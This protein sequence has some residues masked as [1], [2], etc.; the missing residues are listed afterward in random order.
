MTRLSSAAFLILSCAYMTNGQELARPSLIFDDLSAPFCMD[1]SSDG[2]RLAIG[3]GTQ[4]GGD[5]KLLDL[6]KGEWQLHGKQRCACPWSVR[7]SPLGSYVATGGNW[8]T[9]YVADGKTGETYW[10]LTNKGH[11]GTVH[12]ICF[13]PDERFLISMDPRDM[14]I[15]VWDVKA[16]QAHSSFRFANPAVDMGWRNLEYMES[17]KNVFH[18][19]VTPDLSK[20]TGEYAGIDGSTLTSDGKFLVVAGNTAGKV[21]FIDLESG[22][23]IKTIQIKKGRASRL[24]C[25]SDGKWLVAG[26]YHK[27]EIGNPRGHIEIWDTETCQLIKTIGEQE[28]GVTRIALSSDKKTIISGGAF[29]GFRVWDVATGQQKYSYFTK[30]DPRLPRSKVSPDTPDKPFIQ[31]QTLSAGCA[32]LPGDKTFIVLPSWSLWNTE[33]YFHD[34]ATGKLLEHR[35]AIKRVTGGSK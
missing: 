17:A 7:I 2:K 10:D 20:L 1:L 30:T 31:H 18:I 19:D 28:Q 5:W 9:L 33:I 6:V 25:T 16:K 14:T 22:K 8:S 3:G 21:P 29:D 24:L 13:T 27:T 23:I 4:K 12:D 34:T 35:E 26:V 15:R 32:F 11:T